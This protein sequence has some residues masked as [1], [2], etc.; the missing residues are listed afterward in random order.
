VTPTLRFLR[1]LT[2]TVV[3]LSVGAGGHLLGSD[4]LPGPATVALLGLLLLLPVTVLARRQ[5]TLRALVGVLGG[6]QLALHEAFVYFSARAGCYPA[7][8]GHARV[9]S[10]P[11][12]LPLETLLAP[13]H[14]HTSPGALAGH[15]L[16]VLATAWMLR[17]GEE[18]FWQLLLWLRPLVTTL[19]RPPVIA[20]NSAE[21]PASADP[22]PSTPWRALG[23]D[24]VRGPPLFRMA[25]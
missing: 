11:D 24:P 23:A 22:A 3:I 14:H 6:G 9:H 7:H 21:V 16:A 19:R 10:H 4:R 12:C 18:A 15:G 25:L 1:P 20:E 5:L 2:I 17:K 13:A 8:S